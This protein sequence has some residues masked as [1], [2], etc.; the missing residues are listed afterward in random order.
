MDKSFSLQSIL[1]DE[2]HNY[3]TKLKIG[4]VDSITDFRGFKKSLFSGIWENGPMFQGQG[5]E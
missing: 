4:R 1:G 3:S 2:N 5:F